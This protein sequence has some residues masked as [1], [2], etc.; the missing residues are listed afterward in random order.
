M[1]VTTM[2]PL[3]ISGQPWRVDFTLFVFH[4]FFLIYAICILFDYRD[5]ADDIAAGIRSLITYLNEKGILFL[6]I[7]SLLVFF[8]S[9]VLLLNYGYP[10]PAIVVLLLPG[11]ITALLYRKALHNFSDMFYYF[12]LDGLMALSSLLMLLPVNWLNLRS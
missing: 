1:Y 3:L 4:R 8:I 12:T 9:T 6:F 7:F 10:W 5:R 11:L 2:L